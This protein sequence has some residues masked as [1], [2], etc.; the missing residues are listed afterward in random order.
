MKVDQQRPLLQNG[1]KFFDHEGGRYLGLD[2]ILVPYFNGIGPLIGTVKRI[3]APIRQATQSRSWHP[4]LGGEALD[5]REPGRSHDAS[6]T[7]QRAREAGLT[8]FFVLL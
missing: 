2:E 1:Y 3:L 7:K 8:P 4:K 6:P 5:V